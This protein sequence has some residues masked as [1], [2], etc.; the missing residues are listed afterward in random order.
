LFEILIFAVVNVWIFYVSWSSLRHVRS[1]GFYRFFAF[2]VILVLFLMN[3][4]SW[5]DT[6]FAV[7]QIISWFLLLCSLFLVIHGF[8]L[9]RMI[10]KPK[11]NIEDTTVLVRQGAYKYIR[12]PLYSS[13][14][15]GCWGVFFKRPSITGGL[16]AAF[17]TVAVIA[18]AKTEERRN[19]KKFGD[20]Y[21]EYRRST[22]MLIP[23][24]F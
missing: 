13:L 6:P 18:T 10:G 17:G 16:L 8:Y 3:M 2:E 20:V 14:F 5:F 1:H 11:R 7:H 19:L 15:I 4:G 24:L 21:S 9:L 12:H 23:Y 22:K